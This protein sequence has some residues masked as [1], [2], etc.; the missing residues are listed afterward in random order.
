MVQLGSIIKRWWFLSL[1]VPVECMS[2]LVHYTFIC[3]VISSKILH[4]T[5]F[6]LSI[7][8]FIFDFSW[9]VFVGWKTFPDNFSEVALAVWDRPWQARSL[10]FGRYAP[11]CGVW[12][13]PPWFTVN[14]SCLV[15]A[16]MIIRRCCLWMV[17]FRAF[18]YLRPFFWGG[19]TNI[20]RQHS[21]PSLKIWWQWPGRFSGK[22]WTRRKD[23]K[24]STV[25][26]IFVAVVCVSVFW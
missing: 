18:S 26:V 2:I 19:G 4:L 7:C 21:T 6:M 16:N 23:P 8:S 14:A 12:H 20:H 22:M 11:N 24:G 15:K 25:F 17:V 10:R 3:C 9:I 5:F 1:P 13:A